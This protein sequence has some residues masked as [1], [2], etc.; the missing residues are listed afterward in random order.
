M[1]GPSRGSSTAKLNAALSGFA[2]VAFDFTS[3]PFAARTLV[4]LIRFHLVLQLACRVQ[5]VRLVDATIQQIATTLRCP[6]LDVS[7]CGNFCGV[8]LQLPQANHQQPFEGTQLTVLEDRIGR[9]RE[10]GKL[11]AQA[12]SAVH[13]VEALQSV[14]ALFSRGSTASLPQRGHFDAIRPAQL[15]QIISGFLVSCRYGIRC[16]IGCSKGI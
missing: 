8:Q 11:L 6:L 12:H 14:V 9:V 15:S 4:A 16:F 1:D 10:H 3:Q 7:G 13:T 5:M 2:F